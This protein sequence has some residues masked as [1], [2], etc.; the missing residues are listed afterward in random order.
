MMAVVVI[1][2][3]VHKDN[4]HGN[5]D[6]VNGNNNGDVPEH[7]N[8]GKDENKVDFGYMV[9]GGGDNYDGDILMMLAV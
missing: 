2:M 9:S 1:I 8:T 7:V 3:V 5:G 6:K 4:Y